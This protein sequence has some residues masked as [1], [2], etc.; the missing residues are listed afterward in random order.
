[1]TDP[2]KTKM[3]IVIVVTLACALCLDQFRAR[4]LIQDYLP[5]IVFLSLCTYFFFIPFVKF[6]LEPDPMESRSSSAYHAQSEENI[7]KFSSDDYYSNQDN[8][9]SSS[10]H[11]NYTSG[12]TRADGREVDPYVKGNPDGIRENNV[13]YMRDNGEYSS[14][15]NALT[16]P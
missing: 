1:M 5:G 7:N 2:I 14:E 4:K 13:E 10:S 8:N 12:Y 11:Y 9:L 6:L 3:V 15:Y 16:N